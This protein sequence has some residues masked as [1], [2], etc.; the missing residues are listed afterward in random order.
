MN[1]VLA[2]YSKSKFVGIDLHLQAGY[3]SCHETKSIKTLKW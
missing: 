2:R 1:A 3:D